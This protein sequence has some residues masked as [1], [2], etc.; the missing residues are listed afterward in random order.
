MIPESPFCSFQTFF[1]IGH[2]S[3]KSS[4]MRFVKAKYEMKSTIV[5]WNDKASQSALK[6]RTLSL[7]YGRKYLMRS[8]W[9]NKD[10]FYVFR[11]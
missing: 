1:S 11:R 4:C 9:Q 6:E 2:D 7:T 5:P 8:T 10:F 3:Y